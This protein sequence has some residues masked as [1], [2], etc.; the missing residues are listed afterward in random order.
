MLVCACV[1]GAE[2]RLAVGQKADR[3]KVIR[4]SLSTCACVCVFGG[5]AWTYEG[6]NKYFA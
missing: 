6:P 3:S 2:T 1:F 4:D 5:E